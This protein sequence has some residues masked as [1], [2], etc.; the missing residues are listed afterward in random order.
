MR[1]RL[2]DRSHPTPMSS[3][4]RTIGHT[5]LGIAQ[6]NARISA[7]TGHARPELR[8]FGTVTNQDV[9]CVPMQT[10]QHPAVQPPTIS[11]GFLVVFWCCEVVSCDQPNRRRSCVTHCSRLLELGA[12]M[13]HTPSVLPSTAATCTTCVGSTFRGSRQVDCVIT[14]TGVTMSQLKCV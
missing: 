10:P 14:L 5:N 7:E 11:D 6:A 2:L 8:V 13:W 1:G 9:Q 4:A 12:F 3:H